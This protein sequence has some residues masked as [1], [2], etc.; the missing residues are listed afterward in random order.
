[1][2]LPLVGE[3]YFDR[4]LAVGAQSCINLFPQLI[5]DPNEQAKNK[6]AL[7]GTPGKHVI[8]TAS[9]LGTDVR[10][11][12]SGAG[13]LFVVSGNNLVEIAEGGG[14]GA[15]GSR[16]IGG[17]DD[18]LPV[19][20]VSNGLV[21]MLIAGGV[22]YMA[23]GTAGVNPFAI[24]TDVF[25]GVVATSGAELVN[26]VSGD[27]FLTDG[28][29]IG[30][31]ITIN[32]VNYVI[33]AVPSPT[34]LSI[35]T[36][37]A[38]N[39]GVPYSHIGETMTAVTGAV[40]D[41]TFFVQRP[42]TAG[43]TNYGRQVNYSPLLDQT[44]VWSGLSFFSKESYA[45]ALV[46][47]WVDS[48]QLYLGGAESFEVWM[49]NPN[50]TVNQNPFQRIPTGTG[51]FGSFS[52][53]SWCSL[54]GAVYFLGN[55]DRGGPALY[56][57]N[58]FAPVRVSVHGVETQW[59]NIPATYAVVYAYMEEGESFVVVNFY[60]STWVYQPE[61]GA[62]HQRAAWS[63]T[64]FTP[65]L[66]NLHTYIPEWTSPSG[67]QGMH[68]TAGVLTGAPAAIFE[69]SVE[70]Y[71]D[72]GANIACQRALP[73]VYA[74]GKRQYFGRLDLEMETGTATSGSP[75]VTYDYSDDRGVT[76]I[77]PRTAPTGVFS[78]Q[79]AL[80]VWWN[81]NGSSRFRIPRFTIVG[82]S[83]VALIDCQCDVTVGDA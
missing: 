80:R 14:L 17:V 8:P 65:Y 53:W 34:Q 58:G 54:D 66:T 44:G 50:A 13:R 30:S 74:G 59:V 73:Y 16:P 57:L 56:V 51:R 10:G 45:D 26:W 36:W 63:G 75:V 40:L 7:Y 29:W 42:P 81:R 4:S 32:A 60:Y 77:N 62:W 83:K 79:S 11:L 18:G 6:A 46:G 21:L 12:W 27:Q 67:R 20:I 49:S 52:A 78:S 2:R 71:D 72:N 22:A 41:G 3:T 1:M 69:S 47:I 23:P 64:A 76:F 9:L 43:Q 82:Q 68:I 35:A 55:D 5:Q 61:S 25:T 15:Y 31:T 24:T 33:T 19:Q 48:E 28:T 70:F 38:A 37:P 39:A